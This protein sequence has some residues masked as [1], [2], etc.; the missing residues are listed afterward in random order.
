MAEKKFIFPQGLMRPPTYTPVVAA[1]GGRTLY[2]SG[3]VP[4]NEKGELVG[5]GDLG[6]QA[7]QVFRNLDTALKGAGAEFSDV[8][9]ITTYV[10]GYRPELRPLMHQVRAKYVSKENPPASTLVGVQSL[11]IADYLIEVEAIAVSD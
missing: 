3:Q 1:R 2:V 10:V 6:A 11:A 7:E 9:K 8:V 4:V 5:K